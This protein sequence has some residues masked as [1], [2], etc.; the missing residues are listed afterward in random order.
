MEARTSAAE[1]EPVVASLKAMNDRTPTSGR[2][3]TKVGKR[4]RNG[5][6]WSCVG[7]DQDA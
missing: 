4:I 7:M 3:G 2:N 6:H 1:V 5:S